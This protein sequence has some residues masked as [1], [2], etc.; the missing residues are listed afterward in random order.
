MLT[1]A[2]SYLAEAVIGLFVLALL[3]RFYL[4]LVRAPY[5]NPVS[6]FLSALTDFVVLPARR[7]IP[8]LW[9]TDLSSLVLAWVCEVVLLVILLALRG[10]EPAAIGGAGFVAILVLAIVR[11]LKTSVYI[12]MFAVIIQ[13][14][15]SWVS[16]YSPLTPLLNS[17]T[18]PFL[19]PLQKRMPL[20]GG[21]DLSPLVLVLA[22][23]LILILP[24]A[25]LEISV[26][27]LF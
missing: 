8:G 19:R 9:G 18:R 13:A 10:A 22:L 17:L 27:R 25:W 23:Q 5:R 7:F 3:L 24:I 14:V 4:Q 16:T 12:L 26:A 6:Q 11:L 15:L 2:A 21:V 20:V 1:N